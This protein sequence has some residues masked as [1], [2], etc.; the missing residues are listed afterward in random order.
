MRRLPETSLAGAHMRTPHVS[1]SI[2]LKLLQ[3]CIMAIFSLPLR[4]AVQ[5]SMTNVQLTKLPETRESAGLQDC[6][7]LP[8]HPPHELEKYAS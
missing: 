7:D 6:M 5:R 1:S 2:A 3:V 4:R 8:W